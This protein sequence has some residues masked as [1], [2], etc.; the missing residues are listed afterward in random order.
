MKLEQK[1]ALTM[2]TR[3]TVNLNSRG[4][5]NWNVKPC[6]LPRMSHLEAVM[7]ASLYT[8]RETGLV[9]LSPSRLYQSTHLANNLPVNNFKPMY[10]LCSILINHV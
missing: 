1:K 5:L 10:L 8:D 3:L 2:K 4:K 6:Y 7:A 9:D